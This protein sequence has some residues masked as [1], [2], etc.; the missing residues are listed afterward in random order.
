[1]CTVTSYHLVV[2]KLLLVKIFKPL[3]VLFLQQTSYNSLS[4][5]HKP[6]VLPKHFAEI[7]ILLCEDIVHIKHFDKIEFCHL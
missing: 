4:H 2:F 7:K 6:T 3:P 1:M 5:L